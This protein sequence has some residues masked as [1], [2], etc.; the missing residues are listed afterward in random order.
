MRSARAIRNGVCVNSELDISDTAK[1][2]SASGKSSAS[3]D[4]HGGVSPT[5][6]TAITSLSDLGYE[7]E[8]SPHHS[9][10]WSPGLNN[11][12]SEEILLVADHSASSYGTCPSPRGA[13]FPVSSAD[14]KLAV[15]DGKSF[16]PVDV[17]EAGEGNMEIALTDRGRNIQNQVRQ[18]STGQFE[19]AYTPLE[20]SEHTASITFNGEHV[21][22]R[23]NWQK[24]HYNYSKIIH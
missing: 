8:K 24:V 1:D 17:N 4:C 6:L 9:D 2:L 12:F 11:V 7:S 20:A 13:V 14:G 16:L 5:S 21:P 3:C 22:G 10:C 15:N 19:V 23:G 18:L